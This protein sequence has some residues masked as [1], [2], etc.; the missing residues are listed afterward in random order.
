MVHFCYLKNHLD[1]ETVSC[2]LLQWMLRMDVNSNLKKLGQTFQASIYKTKELNSHRIA[3]Y[4]A[5]MAA[6]SFVRISIWSS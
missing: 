2:R 6:V 5:N 4:T 3:V 1:I